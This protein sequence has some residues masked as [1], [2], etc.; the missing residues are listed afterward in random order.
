MTIKSTFL[1]SFLGLFLLTLA[2]CG[3]PTVTPDTP[4]EILYGEDVCDQ[5]NMI[6]NDERYA[7]GLVVETEPGRY[8]HRIFDDIGDLLVYVKG[9]EDDLVIAAYYVH[10][11]NSKEWIDGQT[12]YYIYSEELVTPMGF[13][14]A[15]AA[16][17]L[18]AETLAAEWNGSVLTLTELHERFTAGQTMMDAVHQHGQ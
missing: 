11:Y 13:G 2:A 17:Q 6:I 4:P 14:L 15:A 5:C 3:G 10:D 18:E 12:A 8:E 7:A 16:Q 1:A 9:Q